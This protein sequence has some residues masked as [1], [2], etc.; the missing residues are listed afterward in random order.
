MPTD[1]RAGR[2]FGH[3]HLLEALCGSVGDWRET[4]AK[5]ED[6]GRDREARCQAAPLEVVPV[7]KVHD[8]T[9]RRDAAEDDRLE[10]KGP[11][12]AEQEGFVRHVEESF[13][14]P[15][16]LGWLG[17]VE[18]ARGHADTMATFAPDGGA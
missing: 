5:I 17:D 3:Q 10:R 11:N 7:A 13:E 1:G 2:V 9:A 15:I 16:A 4:P 6:C 12:L 8:S 14:I 18:R